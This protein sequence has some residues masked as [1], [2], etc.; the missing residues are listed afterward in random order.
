M[1]FHSETTRISKEWQYLGLVLLV[2][3]LVMLPI[4]ILG[5]PKGNDLNQHFQ[6]AQAYYDSIMNG[7]WFPSWSSREN[8]GYGSIGIRF[9]PPLAYYIL[10][11][12][13][14][15]SGSWYDA[16]WLAF[17]FWAILASF[18]VYYWS[19]WWLSPSESAI[20]AIA[21]AI[22]PYHLHQ[23]YLSFVY[24]DYAG[25]AILPFCFAFL[26]RLLKRE[27]WSDIL[28]FAISYAALILT[29]LPT[30]IT[31]SLSLGLYTLFLLNKGNW[32]RQCTKAVLGLGA[33][34]AASSYY[35]VRMVSEMGWLVHNEEHYRSGHYYYAN[36][37]FPMY[38]HGLPD[39]YRG[40]FVLSDLLVAS[41]L[42]FFLTAII[43][44]VYR[45]NCGVE[46]DR[47]TEVFRWV[48]PLGLIAFFMTTSISSP[49]WVLLTPMQKIQF[50]MRW[51]SIVA[52]CGAIVTGAAAHYLIKGDFLKR[53]LWI[54]A[55]SG[56]VALFLFLNLVYTWHPSAFIPIARSDFE[57]VMGDLPEQQNYIFWWSIWSQPDALKIK[58]KI[59]AENR[60]AT[61]TNWKPEQR[62]FTIEAGNA[63][64]ARV[65]TFWYPRWQAE[66]NGQIVAVS[67]DENGAILIPVPAE[68]S[69][70]RLV[71]EETSAF[72]IAAMISTITWLLLLGGIAVG[73][74][75][76]RPRLSRPRPQ[77]AEEEFSV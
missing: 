39:E 8:F 5:I 45:R 40:N 14:I 19:R 30:T 3:V 16:A 15:I 34:L 76:F 67:R 77:F 48:L 72:K 10:A 12:G 60:T 26:T 71:F 55:S 54:Y 23:L 4:A 50:P 9:Y 69:G 29:H 58:D 2:G 43:Y 18:G 42:L 70:V 27:K 20:A 32:M 62:D 68:R 44:I 56:F 22:I 63:G 65:A 74:A 24:A 6:F 75:H 38:F 66:V 33:G 61:V 17:M 28:G 13:R 31:G 1:I 52:M 35:W 11:F 57:F 21:Y 47:K 53:R 41:C 7:N 73:F 64:Y 46:A 59:V 37:F 25:A 49:I 36:R 51:M